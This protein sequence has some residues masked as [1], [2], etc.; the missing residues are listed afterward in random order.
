MFRRHTCDVAKGDSASGDPISA[1]IRLLTDLGYVV[2]K[3]P[4]LVTPATPAPPVAK[5]TRSDSPED[6]REAASRRADEQ[7]H[8]MMLREF[9]RRV[10]ISRSSAHIHI[11]RG[12]LKVIKI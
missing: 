7:M 6:R 9:C 4:A 11:H 2:M 1:A 10:A 12:N 8:L 3:V 5:K